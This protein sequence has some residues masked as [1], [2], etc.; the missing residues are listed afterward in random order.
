MWPGSCRLI[1]SVPLKIGSINGLV[2]F[3]SFMANNNLSSLSSLSQL[4]YPYY[5]PYPILFI[6]I[7][8]N[9]TAGVQFHKATEVEAGIQRCFQCKFSQHRTIGHIYMELSM[10]LCWAPCVIK[11]FDLE[12]QITVC[13][14][15]LRFWPVTYQ[16]HLS[17]GAHTFLALC[18]G[19][20]EDWGRR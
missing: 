2:I 1:H 20:V 10:T 6:I 5:S 15:L 16:G 9:A 4:S 7:V 12:H 8:E 18:I 14:L 3:A 19:I 13:N 11:P 17:P